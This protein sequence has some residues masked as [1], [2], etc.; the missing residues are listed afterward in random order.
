MQDA[1]FHG[2]FARNE[3]RWETTRA[4]VQGTCK[5]VRGSGVVRSV[6]VAVKVKLEVWDWELQFFFG[7]ENILTVERPR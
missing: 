5:V 3:A 2:S 7:A 1:I 6:C 4:D